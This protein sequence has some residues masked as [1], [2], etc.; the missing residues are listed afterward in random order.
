MSRSAPRIRPGRRARRAAVAI[1]VATAA[2]CAAQ[3]SA[4]VSDAEI[5]V[6]GGALGLTVADFQ[7]QG[8][9]LTGA[10]QTIATTPGTPWTAVDARGTG[11][12]WSVVASASPLVSAGTP[13]R[14]IDSASLAITTGP[15]TAGTGAD[16]ATGITGADAAA[17]TV[18]TG[19]GQTN[20]AL[21]ATAGPHRGAYS[22]TPRLDVT[23]PANALPSY[24]GVPYAATLTVTIS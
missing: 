11:A 16:P 1:A 15:V 14:V 8:A 19:P 13:D 20:V 18:P 7:P 2:C 6:V 22:F 5:T 4:A 23:L 9:T 3:A 24:P 17:F 10:A 21:L 12:G